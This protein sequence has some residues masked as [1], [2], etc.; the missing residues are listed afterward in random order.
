MLKIT[1]VNLLFSDHTIT[2]AINGTASLTLT[3]VEPYSWNGTNDRTLYL[4]KS[5]SAYYSGFMDDVRSYP[6]YLNIYAM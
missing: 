5:T 2:L 4:G 1:C 3:A 6:I